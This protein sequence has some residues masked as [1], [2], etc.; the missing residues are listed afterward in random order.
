[1]GVLGMK[2]FKRSVGAATRGRS[3][4]LSSL[5]SL[6]RR[7]SLACKVFA[8]LCAAACIL[9]M[10]RAVG[11]FPAPILDV[12][13]W[14]CVG[15]GAEFNGRARYPIYT[16]LA[17][18]PSA[19][20][21]SEQG[22]GLDGDSSSFMAAQGAY[23]LIDWDGTVPIAVEIHE[24]T[25]L[26]FGVALLVRAARIF[27]AIEQAGTP[28]TEESAHGVK[29]AGVLA[30]AA[31]IVS[32]VLGILMSSFVYS[33]YLTPVNEIRLGQWEVG[34]TSFWVLAFGAILVVVGVA[35]EYGVILQRQDDELL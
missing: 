3:E 11:R 26:L 2:L 21:A 16:F 28:F 4:I 25:L 5:T 18:D 10:A 1:M 29:L 19:L 9:M 35:F 31:A 30:V 23:L 14:E 20:S 33:R 13:N 17:E 32:N 27:H 22:G 7:A 24:V 12:V 6:A 15:W 34:A 8:V